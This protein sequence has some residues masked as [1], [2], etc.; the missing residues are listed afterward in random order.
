MTQVR[1]FADQR[2]RKLDDP[3]D[4]SNRRISLIVQYTEKKEE[5]KDAK[6]SAAGEEKK[7]ADEK[8]TGESGAAAPAETSGKK[9]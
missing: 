8:K 4:A 3:L 7:A 5:E 1:G 2:L 9:E 6:P